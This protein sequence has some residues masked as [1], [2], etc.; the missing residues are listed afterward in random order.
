MRLE[1]ADRE[2]A[3]ERE[4]QRSEPRDEADDERAQQQRRAD[5]H[6]AG[7]TMLPGVMP[8]IGAIMI[9][10]SPANPPAIV[11]TIVDVRL[12]LMP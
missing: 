4:R 11:Q 3:D 1:H 5:R 9:A 7:P 10:V 6:G 12:T 8:W 2:P